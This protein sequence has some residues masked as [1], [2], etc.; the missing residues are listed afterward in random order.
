VVEFVA[1]ESYDIACLHQE[2]G[3]LS[4]LLADKDSQIWFKLKCPVLTCRLL[5]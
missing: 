5:L 3:V 4:L 1:Q 2:S